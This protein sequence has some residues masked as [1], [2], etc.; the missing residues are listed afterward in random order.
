M[1][2]FSSIVAIEQLQ[3]VWPEIIP[4]AMEMSIFNVNFSSLNYPNL[5]DESFGPYG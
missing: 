3:G 1:E 5:N 4:V 2:G